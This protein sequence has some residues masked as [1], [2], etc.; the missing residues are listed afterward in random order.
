VLLQA[1][2]AARYRHA[3][4][5]RHPSYF[6]PDFYALLRRQRCAFV[7]ADTAGKFSYAEE[8][9]AGFVYVRLHGSRELYVSGYTDEELDRWAERIRGWARPGGG[10]ARDVY[11]YFDNDAKVHAPHDARRLAA[12]LS[13]LAPD[14]NAG[15]SPG[16][17]TTRPARDRSVGDSQ[18]TGARSTTE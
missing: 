12:R 3:I 5:V 9:T 1:P 7:I 6:H 14:V 10:P 15:R 18:R 8:V 4:E 2:E 11:V 17:A 16:S 13:D